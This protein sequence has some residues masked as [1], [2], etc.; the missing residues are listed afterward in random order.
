MEQRSAWHRG[1]CSGHWPRR[2]GAVTA[3]SRPEQVLLSVSG[4][5]GAGRGEAEMR[6]CG[7]G[8]DPAAR[9]AGQE[10]LPDQE[11]LGDLFHGLALPP[12][13]R[14]R[15]PRAPWP[16]PVTAALTSLGV[17][18]AT[19]MPRRAAQSM[20]TALAW[21]VPITVRTLCWLKT[22]STATNSG[23]CS[24]S[25]CSMP[26]SMATRRWPRSASAG[27]RTTPTPIMVSGRP[28]GSPDLKMPEPTKTPSAPSWRIRAAS[29]GV[30]TPPAENSTTG[31]LPSSE[32]SLT[33]S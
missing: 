6:P 33:S 30:A 5:L 19:G 7:G 4:G 22:R 29:A 20:A 9:S 21:A 28:A 8:G 12:P 25:H 1:S 18:R 2:P 14:P 13:P 15:V 17:C 11:G 3:P 23:R 31:S 27:V 10:S 32:T 24:S 26:R 16:L